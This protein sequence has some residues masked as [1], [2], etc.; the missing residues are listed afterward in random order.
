MHFMFNC[1]MN[2]NFREMSNGTD[3][4]II[5]RK[6]MSEINFTHFFSANRLSQL[7]GGQLFRFIDN[8]NTTLNFEAEIYINI[9]I[10]EQFHSF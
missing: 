3:L 7:P 5:N 2:M 9:M 8:Y 6:K 10:I 4:W 1:G